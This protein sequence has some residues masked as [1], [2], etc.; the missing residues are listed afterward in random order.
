MLIFIWVVLALSVFVF[1]GVLLGKAPRIFERPQIRVRPN[2]VHTNVWSYFWHKLQA[3]GGV[4]WHFILEAKDLKPPKVLNVPVEKVR[5]A[6]RIRVKTSETEP[7]W[8]PEATELVETAQTEEQKSENIFLQAIKKD[9]GN[10]KAFEGLGQLYLQE[11]NFKEA[12]ETF[13]YLV[14]QDPGHDVYWSNLGL[15]LYSLGDYNMAVQAYEKALNLNHKVATRWINLAICFDAMDELTKAIKAVKA[16]L[17]LDKVNLNYLMLLADLYVK[18]ENKI[19]AE[20]VL[21]QILEV[22]PT[23]KLAREKLMALKI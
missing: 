14:N 23:N 17:E 10:L 19:R 2:V 1:I 3:I 4:L 6:F 13:R 9:P 7:D 5:K 11:K 18:I 21:E 8:L 15:S 20:E 12:A 16:A 22:D